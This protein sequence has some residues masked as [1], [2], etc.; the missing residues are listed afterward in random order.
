MSRL[1]SSLHTIKRFIPTPLFRL[2]VSFYHRFLAWLAAVWYRHPSRELIVIGITGT[3]GKST[4]LY[5]A[6]RMLEAAGHK[7]GWS[8]SLSLKIG[9][10][11]WL[12]PYHMT[13]PGRFKLQKL[14]REMVDAGCRYALIEV[15]S[16]AIKQFRHRHIWF[17]GAVFTNLAPEHLEAHGSYEAYR[18]AKLELFRAVAHRPD[19]VLVQG[20]REPTWL[21]AN[22]DDP[23]APAFLDYDVDVK[24]AFR[25]M[26]AKFRSPDAPN[27][28]PLQVGFLDVVD[29]AVGPQGSTFRIME[30]DVELRTPLVGVFNIANIMAAI[31]TVVRQPGVSWEII[32]RVVAETKVIPGRME[33]VSAG[34]PFRV[35]VDLAHT[36][37]SFRAVFEAV[38]TTVRAGERI[39]AVF[40]SA[41]GGRDKWKRPE[42]GKIA[43]QYA[44][45][46]ILTNEDPYDEDPQQ[47]LAAIA[48]GV[49]AV[50]PGT[51]PETIE[52]R[53]EAIR[54]AFKRARTYDTVLL[55]GKGTEQTMVF[56]GGSVPWDD[57]IAAREELEKLGYR[58]S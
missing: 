38:R 3:K 14:L 2:F 45:E 1:D 40:G 41:G 32:K 29:V 58:A 52:D 56:K 31:G 43:A 8:S 24:S 19:K 48:E 33:E 21:V 46:V 42:L 47:I 12:N 50:K 51:N 35:I 17:D 7:I 13:M 25:I 39:I 34:Q 22:F 18:Q 55:F 4:T 57:R 23:E 36:P 53:R 28:L 49:V 26:D 15:T 9:A 44:D 27:V 30:S 11:E 54:A 5:L 37:D 10:R 16:E 20:M 6:G